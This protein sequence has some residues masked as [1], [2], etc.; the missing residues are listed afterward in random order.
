MLT[1]RSKGAEPIWPLDLFQELAIFLLNTRSW[2]SVANS[3]G[4]NHSDSSGAC[5]SYFAM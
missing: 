1:A 5:L 3:A 4:C 2:I